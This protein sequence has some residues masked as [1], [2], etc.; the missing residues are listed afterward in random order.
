MVTIE[1]VM[2]AAQ[3]SMQQIINDQAAMAE[4]ANM[5]KLQAFLIGDFYEVAAPE[6]IANLEALRNA[7]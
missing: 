3:A 7:S 1:E 5:G 4:R 6:K 2:E